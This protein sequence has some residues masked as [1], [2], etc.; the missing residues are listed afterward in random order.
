MIMLI[1]YFLIACNP[2][3]STYEEQKPP[4]PPKVTRDTTE[5]KTEKVEKPDRPPVVKSVKIEPSKPIITDKL[6][7]VANVEDPDGDYIDIRYQWFVNE[8]EVSGE[9]DESLD[10]RFFSRDQQVKVVVTAKSKEFVAS[11]SARALIQN[12]PPKFLNNPSQMR[13]IDGFQFKAED[14]DQDPLSWSISG[15]PPGLTISE[16]GKLTFKGS[17]SDPGGTYKVTVKVDDGH[18]GFATWAFEMN[19]NPGSDYKAD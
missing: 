6:N 13:Q 9:R 3:T 17:T 4:E 16:R 14:I 10:P 1:L 11:G 2:Q 8:E 5:P 12:S 15:G 18:N 7:A 19:V